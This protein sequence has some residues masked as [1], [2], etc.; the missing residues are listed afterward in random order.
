MNITATHNA[1]VIWPC[2]YEPT[3][4][5]ISWSICLT[6]RRSFVGTICKIIGVNLSPSFSIKKRMMGAVEIVTTTLPTMPIRFCSCEMVPVTKAP[7]LPVKKVWTSLAISL[8]SC[9]DRMFCL[10]FKS[11]NHLPISVN[12]CGAESTILVI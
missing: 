6:E 11:S 10:S 4:S 5:F 12:I 9:C 3:F 8:R 7:C 1:T 2:T